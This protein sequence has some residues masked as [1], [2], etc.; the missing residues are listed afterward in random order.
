MRCGCRIDKGG[1]WF[2]EE[3]AEPSLVACLAG[4]YVPRSSKGFQAGCGEEEIGNAIEI[5]GAAD[6]PR[7]RSR[8]LLKHCSVDDRWKSGISAVVLG[9]GLA[10][11]RRLLTV[12][13]SIFGDK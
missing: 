11:S 7:F 1:S 10:R 8:G 4:P 2:G 5:T 3:Y 6:Q 9:E 13:G 12:G